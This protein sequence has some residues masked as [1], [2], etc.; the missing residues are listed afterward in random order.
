MAASAPLYTWDG[1]CSSLLFWISSLYCEGT[2]GLCLDNLKAYWVMKIIQNWVAFTEQVMEIFR[3]RELLFREYQLGRWSWISGQSERKLRF[4]LAVVLVFLGILYCHGSFLLDKC[5][6]D[7][8][9]MGNCDVWV[10]S[11]VYS[12]SSLLVHSG[13]QY[14][15]PFAV[16]TVQRNDFQICCYW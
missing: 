16:V 14:N 15:D 11:S 8:L 4:S 10:L 13:C 3:Y 12:T 2:G 5:F 9:F 7:L 1:H 6:S